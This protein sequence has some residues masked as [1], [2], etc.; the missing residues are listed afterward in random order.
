MAVSMKTPGPLRTMAAIILGAMIG[1][2]LFFIVALAI[3]TIN[4]MMGMNIPFNLKFAEN[5]WSVILL[6]LFI[7]VSI[8][9]MYWMVLITPPTEEE[10]SAADDDILDLDD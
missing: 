2:I 8:A 3:G 1:S 4:G 10:V 5:V 7:G 9:L 6:V